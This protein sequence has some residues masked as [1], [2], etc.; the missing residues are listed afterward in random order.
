MGSSTGLKRNQFILLMGALTTL[1]P[2]T[3][4]MYLPA[5]PILADVYETNASS[6]QLSLTACLLGLAIGQLIAGALS[7]MHGRRKPLLISL[8]AYIVA[9]IACIFA[10]NI[11]LFV[12]LR[13]IQ[14]LAAS[15]GLVISRAIVRDVSSGPE[16]T[17]LF[18]L[19]MVIGNLVPLIAPSIGSGVLLFADWKG[20]FMLLTTL[21]IVLLLLSAF[22]LTESLPS[23]K[24]VP[25]NLKSTFG[26]FA[27]ILRNRQFTGYAL[28]QGFLIGGVFAY[29]SG[30]PF[31]YQNIYGT[32]PQMFSV[33]FGM[34][35]IGLIMGSYAVGRFSYRWSEKKLLET[36]LYTA[37]LAGA[38]LLAVVFIQGPLWA[39]VIPIFFFIMSI[40]VVGTASFTLAMESQ[41]HVA[42]S[43]S[44]LLGLLPFILGAATAPLVGIAGE[45]TAVPMGLVIFSMC[46]IALLAY[47]L[48][49]K[50][51]T[52]S[53]AN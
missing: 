32:S 20:I 48:L 14:G 41:G 37:T 7:D 26:N 50:N 6:V 18:A 30:T 25:S 3:I 51:T 2:F 31:I 24:R 39:V 52:S 36:A 15:G 23:E 49:A 12:F 11:Y 16:L 27:G 44:A 47:L 42:G 5:F 17:R 29:V 8:V 34:N 19:L 38:V 33:L 35:G 43:A 45:N 10:P 46:T 40:G 13:F 28:A 9:S 21:G 53:T 1:V 22:R 4:D